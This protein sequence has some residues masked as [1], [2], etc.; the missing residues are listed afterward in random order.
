MLGYYL[1]R[2]YVKAFFVPHEQQL[3]G[4]LSEMVLC[5]TG[6]FLTHPPASPHFGTDAG[7][8]GK[9]TE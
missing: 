9:G 1:G 6:L 4:V 2:G 8:G 3:L 5:L 7:G